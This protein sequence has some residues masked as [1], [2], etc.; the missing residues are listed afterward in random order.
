MEQPSLSEE[1]R[2]A[3]TDSEMSRYEIARRTGIAPA[4]LSRFMSGESG[5]YSMSLDR[6]ALVLGLTVCRHGRPPQPG[7]ATAPY[8][9]GVL[10]GRARGR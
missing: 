5:L 7:P 10:A 8:P 9:G 3:V 1:V 6:I 2:R 4:S